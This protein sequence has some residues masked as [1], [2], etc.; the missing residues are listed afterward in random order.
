ME[1]QDHHGQ[2]VEIITEKNGYVPNATQINNDMWISTQK[3]C[4]VIIRSGGL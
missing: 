3:R 4:F 1:I 2:M